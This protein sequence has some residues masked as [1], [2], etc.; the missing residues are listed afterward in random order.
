[1]QTLVGGKW[2]MA[3]GA[4]LAILASPLLAPQLLAFPHKVETEIGTVWSDEKL[5]PAMLAD[6]VEYA[7]A[8]LTTSALA[9]A[10]ERRRIFV[11][12]GG[13]RWLY[14]AN[15]ARG[16]F[17][18]SRPLTRAIIINRTDPITGVIRNG[19]EVGGQRSLGGVLAHEFT[20]GMIQRRYGLRAFAGIPT[21]K[22]EGYA[23]HV[24]G[25]TSLSAQDVAQL[26]AQG[27]DHPALIY[28]EG[29]QRVEAI[30]RANGG[31]P[32]ALFQGD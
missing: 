7:Q 4:V 15:T 10:D 17:G 3:L 28:Y 32:D 24:A 31:S 16:S 23:E 29:R 6:A 14:T 5:D 2:S 26:R 27:E 11:T 8:R 30:L 12:D 18:I 25:E 9:Q 1:M 19:R 13:W 20:H 21:W 22:I